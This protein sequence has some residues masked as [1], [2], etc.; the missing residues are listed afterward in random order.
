MK[1]IKINNNKGNLTREIITKVGETFYHSSDVESVSIIVEF[2][3]GS[4]IKFRR[5]EIKDEIDRQINEA[6]DED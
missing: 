6:E 2:K 4:A 3:D 5:A 1:T